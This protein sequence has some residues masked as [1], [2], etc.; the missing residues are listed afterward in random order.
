VVAASLNALGAIEFVPALPDD[1]WRRSRSVR[2]R[3]GSRSSSAPAVPLDQ[4]AVRPGH[5]FGYLGSESVNGD[6]SQLMIGFGPDAAQ[7]DA[8]DLAEVQDNLDTI[9]PGYDVIDATAHD[10]LGDKFSR[11]V[12][13]PPPGLVRAPSSRDAT[14]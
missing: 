11:H 6:G 4:N 1:S 8:D 14:P 10:W 3:A 7:C 9:M 12:G 2:P 13:D 5:A